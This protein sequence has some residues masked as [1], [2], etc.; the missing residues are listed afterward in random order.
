M[1]RILVGW[2]RITQELVLDT[3]LLKMP[4]IQDDLE[5][6]RKDR[7]RDP[8]NAWLVWTP[9]TQQMLSISEEEVPQMIKLAMMMQE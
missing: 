2:C 5:V 7:N 6:Y 1:S 9:E 4:W 3:K 8:V